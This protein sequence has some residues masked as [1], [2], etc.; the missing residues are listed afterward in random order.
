MLLELG[1]ERS[2]SWGRL[3]RSFCSCYVEDSE[4]ESVKK[5]Q[6]EH[7]TDESSSDLRRQVERQLSILRKGLRLPPSLTKVMEAW[8]SNTT[9]MA[10]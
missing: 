8:F 2:G 5:S 10:R 4:D 6:T 1:P 9:P 7:S 3:R